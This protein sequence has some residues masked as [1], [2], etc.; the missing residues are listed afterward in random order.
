ME[1]CPSV[2]TV[3]VRA[4]HRN[5]MS[6][7]GAGLHGVLCVQ[8][9]MYNV[10]ELCVGV[11]HRQGDQG[12][13]VTAVALPVLNKAQPQS[14]NAVGSQAGCAG[15][16]AGKYQLRTHTCLR[17]VSASS[18]QL[19]LLDVVQEDSTKNWTRT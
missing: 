12:G 11:R 13:Q 6:A 1:T 9:S 2:A 14:K 4:Q 3:C 17:T 8:A 19:Q 16:S 15:C 7:H 10:R 5:V 18:S